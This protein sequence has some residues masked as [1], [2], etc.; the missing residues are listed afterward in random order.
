[1]MGDSFYYIL[2]LIDMAE[3]LIGRN[4]DWEKKMMGDS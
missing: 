3:I 4:T 1:M 2:L